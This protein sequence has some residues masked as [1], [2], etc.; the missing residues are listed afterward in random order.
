M[1]LKYANQNQP[2]KVQIFFGIRCTPPIVD[3]LGVLNGLFTHFTQGRHVST[4]TISTDD[5]HDVVRGPFRQNNVD[6]E[7]SLLIAV[8]EPSGVLI[9]G[10]DTIT[11]HDGKTPTTISSEILQVEVVQCSDRFGIY[12][13]STTYCTVSHKLNINAIYLFCICS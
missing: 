13:P 4:Y 3:F 5:S 8:S 2:R 12:L 1:I 7:A 9:I 10:Q 6:T 11:F